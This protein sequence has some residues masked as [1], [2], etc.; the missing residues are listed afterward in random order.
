M[1][2]YEIT[3]RPVMKSPYNYFTLYIMRPGTER[4]N[5]L[6]LWR[7]VLVLTIKPWTA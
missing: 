7:Y 4:R 3:I 2:A 6:V 5:A 1:D